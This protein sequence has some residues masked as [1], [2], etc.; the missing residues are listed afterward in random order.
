MR[1]MDQCQFFLILRAFLFLLT[2]AYEEQWLKECDVITLE[3]EQLGSLV[4][5]VVTDESDFSLLA[6]KKGK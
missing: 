1:G 5:T 4:N 2:P 6:L 3:V